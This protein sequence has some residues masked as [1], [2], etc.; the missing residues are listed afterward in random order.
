MT[1]SRVTLGFFQGF[2][3]STWVVIFV[4][5]FM[6]QTVS[7]VLKYCD[8]IT[9]RFATAASLVVTAVG[10]SYI[11]G[12]TISLPFCVGVA[13]LANAFALYYIPGEV[14]VKKDYEVLGYQHL[15]SETLK[16]ENA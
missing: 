8:N 2:T 15:S 1:S 12:T 10:S 4:S 5:A 6:G 9:N 13:I 11:F 7:F 3:M 14:L 16:D